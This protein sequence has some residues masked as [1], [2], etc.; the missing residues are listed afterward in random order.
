MDASDRRGSFPVG[1]PRS[2]QQHLKRRQSG[3]PFDQG[4][5]PTDAPYRMRVKVP[6]RLG[7]GGAVIVDQDKR[8]VHLVPVVAGQMNL[9]DRGHWEG[10]KMA[11]RFEAEIV[12]ADMD[13][14]HIAQQSAAGP[15]DKG[16][17][18]LRFGNE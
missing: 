2:L 15:R 12:G 16:R 17:Q 10:V 4:R 9:A 7:Y 14:V 3:I 5:Y 11:A 1:A 8:A 13:V 18:K 6:Y